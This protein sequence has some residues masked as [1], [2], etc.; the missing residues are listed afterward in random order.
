MQNTKYVRERRESC[1]K[2]AKKKRPN[3]GQINWGQNPINFGSAA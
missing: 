1:A 3:F 2:D